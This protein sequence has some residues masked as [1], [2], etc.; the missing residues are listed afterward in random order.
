MQINRDDYVY[1]VENMKKE[2]D[3]ANVLFAEVTLS[4]LSR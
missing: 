3:I 4:S 2:S 1:I